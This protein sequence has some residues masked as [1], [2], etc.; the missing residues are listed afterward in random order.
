MTA[1]ATS[2]GALANKLSSVR[3]VSPIRLSD[4][5]IVDRPRKI[6]VLTL[7]KAASS[8]HRKRGLLADKEWFEALKR[9]D[10]ATLNHLIADDFTII[11][12]SGALT[13]KAHLLAS[14]RS[15]DLTFKSFN[16]DD[17]QVRIYKD[18]ALVIGCSSLKGQYKG[19]EFTARSRYTH[20][21][22]NQGGQWQIVSAQG[23]L[24][25]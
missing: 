24:I 25:T 6:V 1:G 10:I 14:L 9:S 19:T 4:V 2:R 7:R 21:Y 18:M 13:N 17:L 15:G 23:T 5:E 22:V 8:E 3:R 16:P 12:L 11:D 20:V